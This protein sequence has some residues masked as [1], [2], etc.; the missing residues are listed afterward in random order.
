MA[1]GTEMLF[2]IVLGFL[3]L[4]PKQLPA[5]LDHIARARAQFKRATHAFTSEL[6]VALERQGRQQATSSETHMGVQQ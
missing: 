1:F 3:L 4:G 6:D 2:V 5:L